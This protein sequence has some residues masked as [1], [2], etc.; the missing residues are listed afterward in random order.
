MRI[1]IFKTE[2]RHFVPQSPAL[3][4]SWYNGIRSSEFQNFWIDVRPGFIPKPNDSLPKLSYAPI[5]PDLST[6]NLAA[7]D[8]QLIPSKNWE[9]SFSNAKYPVEWELRIPK[10]SI[11]L[12]ITTPVENQELK[13]AEVYWEGCIRLKGERE[14]KPVDGLGYMELTGYA[15]FR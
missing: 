11:N 9:S 14:S 15:N 12:K 1:W 4:V 13:L 2:G 8:F 3:I 7:D 10:L 6:E 5:Q